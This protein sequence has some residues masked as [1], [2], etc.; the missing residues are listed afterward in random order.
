MIIDDFYGWIKYSTLLRLL[1]RYPMRVEYK[2]GQ[3]NFLAKTII[4]TSNRH[5]SEWYK[6][7]NSALMRR[8]TEI[9]RVDKGVEPIKESLC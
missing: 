9:W 5:P 4:F 8:I 3:A 6:M 7:D 2:G 1:D